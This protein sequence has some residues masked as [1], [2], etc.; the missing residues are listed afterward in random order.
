MKRTKVA[1]APDVPPK[2]M[3]AWTIQGSQTL[4]PDQVRHFQKKYIITVLIRYNE[5]FELTY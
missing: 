2:Q 3:A 1:I 5:K 4:G